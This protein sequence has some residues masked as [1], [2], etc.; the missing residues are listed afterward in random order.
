MQA[1]GCQGAPG[2]VLLQLCGPAESPEL[3]NAV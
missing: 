2:G 3:V 1:G